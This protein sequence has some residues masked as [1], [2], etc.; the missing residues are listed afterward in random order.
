VNNRI[1]SLS[2]IHF[3]YQR[4]PVLTGVNLEVN[5]GDFFGLVGPN[6]AGKTT[7]LQIIV[8]LL[9]PVSGQVELFGQSIAGFKDWAKVG[10]V[11]QRAAQLETGFPATVTEFVAA[12]R[13]ARVGLCRKFTPADREAVNWALEMVGLQDHRQRVISH[14]SGGL[15]QR[16]ALGRA[17]AGQPELMLLDEPAVGVDPAAREK[18]Y[19]LLVD[20]IKDLRL[21]LI[22]VSHDIGAVVAHA[23]NVA[24]LNRVI[25]FNGSAKDM[26]QQNMLKLYGYYDLACTAPQQ[27]NTLR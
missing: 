8:G 25:I 13:F 17:L 11:S 21:T 10:Y 26:L 2:Q 14:L 18:F 19:H 1:V 22:L 7:L 3:S 27:V 6:G 24:W 20:L 9:A 16:A 4:E 12:G 5:R 23:T 15:K